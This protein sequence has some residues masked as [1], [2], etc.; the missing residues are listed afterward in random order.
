VI[1]QASNLLFSCITFDTHKF[2]CTLTATGVPE[3][4]AEAFSKAFKGSTAQSRLC[5]GTYKRLNLSHLYC[6]QPRLP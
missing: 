6:P 1:L 2:I 4:Q 3:S 5:L